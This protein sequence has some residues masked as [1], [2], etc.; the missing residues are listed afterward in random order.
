M[1]P[2]SRST[3]GTRASP[4]GF[5]A[6]LLTQGSLPQYATKPETC[7]AMSSRDESGLVIDEA[8]A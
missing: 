6:G 7:G 1:K 3:T 4:P 5:P 8:Q 2:Q